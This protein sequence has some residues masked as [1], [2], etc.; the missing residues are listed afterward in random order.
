MSHNIFFHRGLPEN[1]LLVTSEG[2]FTPERFLAQYH[3]GEAS[4]SAAAKF[5]CDKDRYY[6]LAPGSP[7]IDVGMDVGLPFAGRAPD[8]G[9]KELGSEAT[10]PRYPQALIDVEDDEDSILYLWGKIQR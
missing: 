3:T 5:A 9:W 7:G 10:A 1:A 2:R 6:F 8:V 4:F